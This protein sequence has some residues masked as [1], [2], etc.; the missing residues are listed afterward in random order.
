MY[1]FIFVM[2]PP[3]VVFSFSERSLRAASKVEHVNSTHIFG[4]KKA[5]WIW[6]EGLRNGN[7]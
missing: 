4:K 1:V 7:V 3:T 6:S 2:V 5:F